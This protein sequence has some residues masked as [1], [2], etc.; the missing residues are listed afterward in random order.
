[1]ARPLTEY[2]SKKYKAARAELLRDN[3][4]CHWCKRAPATELDHLVPFDEGG[5]ID[6]GYVQACK[7]CNSRRGAEYINKKTAIR[8]QNRNKILFDGTKMPDRKSVV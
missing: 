8:M 3:P 7:P 4:T 6:D 1:M 2:D 5:T